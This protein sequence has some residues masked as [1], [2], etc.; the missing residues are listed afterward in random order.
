M[1]QQLRLEKKKCQ[2]RFVLSPNFMQKIKQV[3]PNTIT[4]LNLLS[5]CIGIV[6]AFNNQLEYA[7]A[8]IWI[9]GLFD[10]FDGFSARILKVSSEIGK[11]LDSLADMVTFGVLPG[12]IIYQ[13]ILQQQ[14]DTGWSEY[15]AYVAFI[16]TIFSAI[17][18]AKFNIDTRQSDTF[19]GLPTP[20]NAFCISAF[21]WILSNPHVLS[22]EQLILG[23]I[24]YTLV[25]SWLLVADIKMLALKFK[26]FDWST[27]KARWIFIA[28]SLVFIAFFQV[29]A[30][31]LV[32]VLY[33]FIS[34]IYNS[35][36]HHP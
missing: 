3:I 16:I 28:L 24:V 23:L 7:A 6:L 22:N 1:A 13:L 14:A 8:M 5:G 10:F 11:Q 4:S 35:L 31:P 18:L 19:I 33:I 36:S 30:I 34:V 2:I 17:R 21:P 25:F 26:S 27:N 9:A 20:A 15:I 12:V 32:I 29:I